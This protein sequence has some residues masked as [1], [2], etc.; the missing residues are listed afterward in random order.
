MAFATVHTAEI[1]PA[2]GGILLLIWPFWLL[3][4][5]LGL[6]RLAVRRVS[7]QRLRASGIFDLDAMTEREF[8]TRIAGLFGDLGYAV[9]RVAEELVVERHGFR[10]VLRPA[11]RSEPVGS[12]AVRSANAART[13][14][15][16]DGAW[17]V[18]NREFTKQALKLASRTGV[19]LWNRE[20]L[21]ASLRRAN[22]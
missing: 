17:V 3:L 16:A 11:N 22:A 13:F 9:N 18:T 5:G 14:H 20:R 2:L 4:G 21:V 1:F 12:D 8:D 19:D 7:E 6:C 15:G 10:A